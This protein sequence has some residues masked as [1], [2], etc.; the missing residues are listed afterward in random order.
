MKHFRY[1]DPEIGHRLLVEY[2]RY[3]ATVLNENFLILIIGMPGKGKSWAAARLASLIDPLFTAKQFCVSYAEFLETMKQFAEM[4]DQG[5]DVSGR[6]VV[7]DEFQ[8]GAGARKWHSK[9]NEAINDVL[10]TFRYLNLIVMFTS[11]HLSFIDINARA[12]M[13]CQITMKKKHV[14]AGFSEAKVTFTEIKNDPRNPSDK[15]FYF[16]PRLKSKEGMLRLS[17]MY[18]KK[19]GTALRNAL[20]KKINAFKSDTVTHAI[21]KALHDEAQDKAA[22]IKRT[23]EEIAKEIHGQKNVYYNYE[24]EMWDSGAILLDY[25]D[26]LTPNSLKAVKQMIKAMD[27][28]A[29]AL[30]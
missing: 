13:H 5:I 3:I 25:K 20:D 26:E 14:R 12:V 9:V 10:Q 18:F 1:G 27:R 30:I 17:S 7:F 22:D 15:L 21:K 4:Y 24:K 16:A 28:R 2:P 29:G 19:P 11:P 6:V 23:R 8:Q